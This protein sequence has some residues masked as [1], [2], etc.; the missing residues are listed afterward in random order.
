MEIVKSESQPQLNGMQGYVDFS[1]SA[2]S[3][4]FE[5][6]EVTCYFR[7]SKEVP[8]ISIEKKAFESLDL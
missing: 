1:I 4:R 7:S 3:L 2:E 8:R 5:Q 6:L